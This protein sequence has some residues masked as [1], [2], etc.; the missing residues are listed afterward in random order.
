MRDHVEDEALEA[1]GY[2]FEV[3]LLRVLRT[4]G[5]WVKAE[6]GRR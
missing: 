5:E 6:R 4:S 2:S 3:A 1:R